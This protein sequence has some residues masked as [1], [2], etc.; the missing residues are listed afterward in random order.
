MK[1]NKLCIPRVEANVTPKLIYEIFT[2]LDIGN[3]DTITI[4]TK[5]HNKVFIEFK[6]WYDNKRAN[7]IKERLDNDEPVNIMY[8]TRFWKIKYAYYY[9]YKLGQ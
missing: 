3:I 5:N 1:S 2:R 8:Q 7:Y 6:N 9:H 4:V